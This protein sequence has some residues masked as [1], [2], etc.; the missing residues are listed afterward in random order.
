[1]LASGGVLFNT[2]AGRFQTAIQNAQEQGEWSMSTDAKQF[3]HFLVMQ[4]Q[5]I[6]VLGKARQYELVDNGVSVLLGLLAL[7]NQA[8][9]KYH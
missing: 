1:V 2:L 9:N 7:Q 4:M 8:G 3:S 6:R 5:G